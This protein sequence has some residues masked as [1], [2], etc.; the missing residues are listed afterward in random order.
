MGISDWWTAALGTFKD[1]P[2]VNASTFAGKRFAVDLSIWMNRY[3]RTDID[4]LATTCNP[5]YPALD[6]LG[7]IKDVH[8]SLTTCKIEL[9]YVFDGM[10]PPHKNACKEERRRERER[11]GA[12]WL[13][14]RRRA[15]ED[16]VANFTEG[17]LKDGVSSRMAMKHPTAVDHAYILKWMREEKIEHYGSI[18]E[19]DQQMIKLEQDGIVDG[20]ISE[21]GDEVALGAKILL[22]KMKR[23]SNGEYQFKVYDRE[24]FLSGGNPFQ[25]K[26]CRYPS[27]IPDAALL[28]G[29][30]YCK[31][32]G[33]NGAVKVL[34]GSLPSLPNDATDAQKKNRKRRDDSMIDRLA[35]AEDKKCWL[36]S[37]GTQGKSEMPQEVATVYWNARRYM[38]HAPVLQ[39]DNATGAVTV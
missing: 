23:K 3:T 15:T 21:D 18:A 38:L 39:Q 6:L 4:K 32:I 31:M 22:C 34:L 25:S 17:E 16:N 9:V 30:D 11:I 26:L 8:N 20:I 1:S 24:H 10:A 12:A 13:E 28:L 36:N 37:Y 33:A 14:L 35:A 27:L 5:V 2:Y 29:N 19:A 7:Y